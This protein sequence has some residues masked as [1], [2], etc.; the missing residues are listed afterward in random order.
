MSLEVAARTGSAAEKISAAESSYRKSNVSDALKRYQ[1]LAGSTDLDSRTTTFAQHRVA[2]LESEKRLAS[3]EWID[4][5]PSNTNDPAWNVS[6]GTVRRNPDSTLEI[7]SDKFGHMLFSRARVGLNFE[8]RGEFELVK[9]SNGEFQAGLVMGLPNFNNTDWYSF[10]MKRNRD[11]GEVASFATGWSKQQVARP[12]ALSEGRNSFQFQFQNGEVTASVNGKQVLQ[13][14]KLPGTLRASPS[15]FLV[16]LG[17][18]N[19]M[20]ETTL[21]YHQV[22]LRRL[23]PARPAQ[24]ASASGD[25]R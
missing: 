8:V 24:Q 6:F 13:R 9:S 19:D 23:T 2:A 14:A 4:L 7:H 15:E 21:R 25:L 10:R 16:G 18:Y 1:E 5:L 11:E 17:A 22:Q 12:V 20:N 3:G